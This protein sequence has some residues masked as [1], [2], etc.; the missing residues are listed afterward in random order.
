MSLEAALQAHLIAAA[1][2]AGARVY[3]A[4]HVPPDVRASRSGALRPY[5]S[6]QRISTPERARHQSA[7][8]SLE[9]ARFQLN[10]WAATPGAALALKAQ[11]K[12]LLESFT[13]TLGSGA[14]TATVERAVVDDDRAD[15]DAP[16]DASALGGEHRCLVDCLIWHKEA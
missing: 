7:A 12:T 5:L 3:P 6:Y 16:T 8:S 13:G 11:V 4:G 10:C 14:D 1:T 2:A 15:F 9:Q